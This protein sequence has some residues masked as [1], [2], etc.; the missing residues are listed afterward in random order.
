MYKIAFFHFVLFPYFTFQRAPSHAS[1]SFFHVEKIFWVPISLRSSAFPLMVSGFP[2]LGLISLV[3]LFMT[4][5]N[6]QT[7]VFLFYFLLRIPAFEKF[8][9]RYHSEPTSGK[10]CIIIASSFSGL[11]LVWSLPFHEQSLDY[12]S[13]SNFLSGFLFYR[14]SFA[15]I[16]PSYTKRDF[17]S[18]S[19][20]A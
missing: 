2:S 15:I 20:L 10:G 18:L 16:M 8:H 4:L 7:I 1:V 19:P 3:S 17:C 13:V 5:R 6:S 11:L 14:I 9:L 12:P